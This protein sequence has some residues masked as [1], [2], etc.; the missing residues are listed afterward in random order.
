MTTKNFAGS[1]QTY[2]RHT[3]PNSKP[4]GTKV[5]DSLI[6]EKF[7]PPTGLRHWFEEFELVES[8]I[9]V[10]FTHASIS[11][12]SRFDHAFQYKMMT[13]ILPT[14]QYLA[15]YKIRDSDTCDKCHV[16]TD[17]IF[18]RI[19]QCQLVVPFVVKVTDFL[20]Q[21]CKLQ[22]NIEGIQYIFNCVSSSK[23]P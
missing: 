9:L 15:R 12:K 5:Y 7:R 19:Y 10:G 1:C 4:E 21:Q 3:T 6:E 22:E 13:Q 14:N 2:G 17:T 18:H 16:Y 23:I 11:S 20:K 8:D